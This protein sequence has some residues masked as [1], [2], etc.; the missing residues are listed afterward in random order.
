MF[1]F[2]L[3]ALETRAGLKSFAAF[4]FS[5]LAVPV[6]TYTRALFFWRRPFPPAG[7]FLLCHGLLLHQPGLSREKLSDYN[8]YDLNHTCFSYAAI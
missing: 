6:Y 3:F 7:I 2:L 1:V 5:Q 8:G 4:L